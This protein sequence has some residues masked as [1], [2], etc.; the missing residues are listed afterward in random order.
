MLV[1]RFSQ[2]ERTA[3]NDCRGGREMSNALQPGCQDRVDE[4]LEPAMTLERGDRF[5]GVL[6]QRGIPTYPSPTYAA[7]SGTYTVIT[8]FAYQPPSGQWVEL[9]RRTTFVWLP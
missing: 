9:A 8:T 3:T 1:S 6:Y 5:T 7:P 4:P 2:F